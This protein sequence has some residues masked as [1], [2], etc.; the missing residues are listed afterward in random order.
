M[1]NLHHT[2]RARTKSNKSLFN[3]KSRPYA[4]VEN[5]VV[6]AYHSSI[7]TAKAHAERRAEWFLDNMNWRGVK[8]VSTSWLDRTRIIAAIPP[9]N[10]Q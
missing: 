8:V 5:G 6:I 4:V 7:K 10:W 1:D 2:T 3:F 9:R